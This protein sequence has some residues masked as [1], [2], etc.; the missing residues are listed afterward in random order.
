M[1]NA[2]IS[3]SDKRNL[4]ELCQA[5]NQRSFSIYATPG[6]S[7]GQVVR[8]KKSLWEEKWHQE[9]V[10]IGVK[11][12]VYGFS[13]GFKNKSD[14]IK[15]CLYYCL[16]NGKTLGF[17]KINRNI[18]KNIDVLIVVP[19]MPHDIGGLDLIYFGLKNDSVVVTNPSDYAL[20]TDVLEHKYLFEKIK[21]ELV[22]RSVHRFS[23]WIKQVV[24]ETDKIL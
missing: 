12:V 16:T 11:E 1:G 24:E 17:K 2:L 21:K 22:N 13:V 14:F 15:N 19:E 10:S 18:D 3:V 6:T 9:F 7:K 8:A 23:L 20:L 4:L 5:L